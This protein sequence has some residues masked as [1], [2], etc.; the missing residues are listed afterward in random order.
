MR[1]CTSSR[2]SARCAIRGSKPASDAMVRTTCSSDVA[3]VDDPPGVGEP[4]KDRRRVVIRS[5]A[6]G[7][8]RLGDAELPRRAP[9]RRDAQ[10]RIEGDGRERVVVDEREV[11]LV[12]GE[13]LER[14]GGLVL[15]DPQA[16]RRVLGGEPGEHRDE[17]PAHCGG[18]ARDAHRPGG[19]TVGVEVG[20]GGLERREDRYGVVGEAPPGGRQPD[21]A[22][23]GL[24]QRRARLAPEHGELCETVEVV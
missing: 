7:A 18:E 17:R 23:L 1:S 5:A 19:L 6:A 16:D 4:P 14:L 3:R 21:A 22:A 24:D 2:L 20:A 8:V 12:R 11:D 15:V 10:R 13:E 9:Q